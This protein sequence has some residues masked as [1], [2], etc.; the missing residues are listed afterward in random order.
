MNR[1]KYPYKFA[2]IGALSLGA[3]LFIFVPLAQNLR[4]TMDVSRNELMGVEVAKPLLTLIKHVQEHRALSAGAL[5]GAESM[6]GKRA[7]KETDVETALKGLDAAD[8]K[9]GVALGISTDWKKVKEKWANVRSAGMNMS[10]SDNLAAHTEIVTDLLSLLALVGDTSGLILD[11]DADSYYA[12]DVSIGKMPDLLERLG[13]L[14]GMGVVALTKRSLDEQGRRDFISNVA[15]LRKMRDDLSESLK[16]VVTYNASNASLTSRV[17]AFTPEFIGATDRLM[18]LVNADII[19]GKFSTSADTYFTQIT[20]S[21]DSGYRQIDE[22]FLPALE[23]LL[24]ARLAK[25]QSQ[26]YVEMGIALLAVILFA[27][28]AIGAYLAIMSGLRSLIQGAERTASGD[29]TMHIN[30]IAKDELQIVADRYNHM[31]DGVSQLI[32]NIRTEATNVSTAAARL[33]AS[34]QQVSRG[35]AEQSEAAAGM[36]AAVEEMT[37]SVDEIN[38]HAHEAQQI[39][40]K[41]GALSLQGNEIVN[42]AVNEMAATASTVNKS[43][44]V[45]EELGR[46]SEKISAIVNVIKQIAD[47]T[48]LLALNAAI[49]AA[50]AGESGRGFAVVADE[51]RKLAERT[52]TATQEIGGM[53]TSIQTGTT[54]AVSSMQEGVARVSGSVEMVHKAGDSMGQVSQG[55]AH[56]VQVIGDISVALKEQSV[57]NTDIARNVERIAQMANNNHAAV[58]ESATTA[59]ELERLSGILQ[60]EINRFRVK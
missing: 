5:S 13:R 4:A 34:S 22:L 19:S 28:F 18:L 40:E 41:S 35:S 11:P 58:A 45:I 42:A 21:I 49:E 32:R 14:R 53:I 16:K 15:V 33:A 31:I 43:A 57:A 39:S 6:K 60:R 37:V 29:L 30:V 52:G 23:N 26:F 12:M 56:V 10:P 20:E 9:Y 8:A 59:S 36:A 50:R 55:T 2:V 47:Q 1:L 51:V 17:G 54:N 46:Q 38:R 27:Y 24:N 7:A 44:E 3:I 25:A 48:N